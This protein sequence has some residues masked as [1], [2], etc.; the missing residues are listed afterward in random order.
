MRSGTILVIAIIWH[1]GTLKSVLCTH[2]LLNVH[3]HRSYQGQV[4]CYCQVSK[5][6]NLQVNKFQGSYTVRNKRSA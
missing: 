2:D 5:G 3:V 4:Y 6:K 1:G